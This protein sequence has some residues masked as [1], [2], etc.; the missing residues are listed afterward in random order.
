MHISRWCFVTADYMHGGVRPN[1]GVVPMW[2]CFGVNLTPIY[3]SL[4]KTTENVERLRRRA[5]HGLETITSRVVALRVETLSFWWGEY[6]CG[7]LN[8][9][10]NIIVKLN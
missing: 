9:D 8:F 3:V 5:R 1:R 4:K 10:F 7:K 6:Q 2:G